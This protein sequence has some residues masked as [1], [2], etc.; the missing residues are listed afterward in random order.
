M[1][2]EP[3]R[4]NQNTTAQRLRAMDRRWKREKRVLRLISLFLALVI[5]VLLCVVI[6]D[7]QRNTS[8]N[9]PDQPTGGE[10][11]PGATTDTENTAPT[12]S[13]DNNHTVHFLAVGDN[14]IHDDIYADARQRGDGEYLFTPMYEGVAEEIAN[15]DVAYINQEGPVAPGLSPSGYPTFNAPASI[16]ENLGDVGFDVIN[17]ANNHMTDKGASGLSQTTAC[18][19]NQ[20]AN[21]TVIGGYTQ[22]DYDQIRVRE[23][24]GI[25]LAFL[26]Y[27]TFVNDPNASAVLSNDFILPFPDEETISRQVSLARQVADV[28]IVSMHWG[29]ENITQPTAQMQNWA[30]ILAAQNVDVVLGMHSHTLMPIEWLDGTDGHQTLVAYS[31][32]NFF[33]GMLDLGNLVGGLFTF[34]IVKQGDTVSIN[35][36]KL[37]PTV[38]HYEGVYASNADNRHSFGVYLLRDYT[39]EMAQ[40]HGARAG[41][42][43]NVTLSSLRQQATQVIDESILQLDET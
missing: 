18:F 35:N 31:L 23:C 8:Q 12:P 3:R 30:N 7:F 34:D 5:V 2:Q 22:Q 39:E 15:A 6:V 25:K 41:G 36:V 24:N 29:E 27:T 1:N 33:G 40:K 17:L 28:V 20:D 13:E 16:A 42:T 43:A 10:P 26:S 37:T 14:I 38:I 19:V 21:Y 32:G 9:D 11:N 4:Q